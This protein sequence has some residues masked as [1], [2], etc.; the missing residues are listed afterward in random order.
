MGDDA[1]RVVNYSNVTIKGDTLSLSHIGCV[2]A[3]LLLWV[4]L[5]QTLLILAWA[6]CCQ[7]YCFGQCESLNV[8][9]D[10]NRTPRFFCMPVTNT[11]PP[12]SE[13]TGQQNICAYGKGT[14]RE[15]PPRL[16]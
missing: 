3:Y 5:S 13:S 6:S 11:H 16:S 7:F 2:L 12:Y 9:N 15:Q 10:D 14:I 4:F 8:W 1:A